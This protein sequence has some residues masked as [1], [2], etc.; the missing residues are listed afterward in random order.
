MMNKKWCAA[1]VAAATLAGGMALAGSAYADEPEYSPESWSVA[2][3]LNTENKK[4]YLQAIHA[5]HEKAEETGKVQAIF[6]RNDHNIC[7][8]Y[9]SPSPR[10]KRQSRMPSSA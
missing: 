8:L 5:A 6:Y 2:E 10:D 1:I 4:L 9:T 3:A 7:L